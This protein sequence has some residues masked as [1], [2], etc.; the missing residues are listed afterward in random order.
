VDL[1][2]RL[3]N[4]DLGD[5]EGGENVFR[6]CCMGKVYYPWIIKGNKTKQK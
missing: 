3:G 6:L 2:G 4:E 5:V 1:D